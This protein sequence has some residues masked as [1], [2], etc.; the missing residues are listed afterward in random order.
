MGI[1]LPE[2]SSCGHQLVNTDIVFQVLSTTF[3]ALRFW[4]AIR[5]GRPLFADDVLICLAYA[6]VAALGGV[7]TWGVL[8]GMGK[9]LAEL[10]TAQLVIQVKALL[11]VQFT[12][13]STTV[14]AKLSVIWLLR[15]IYATPKFRRLCYGLMGL[16]LVYF[17]SFT[18]IY[19][20]NCIPISELWHH[21]PGGHCRNTTTGDY[22]T[23]GANLFLDALV[24]VLPLPVL[25]GLKMSV[26]DKITITAMFSLGTLTMTTLLWRLAVTIKVRSSPEWVLT[27]CQV[28]CIAQIELHVS[29]IAACIPTLGPLFNAYI[30]PIL[31]KL[32]IITSSLNRSNTPSKDTNTKLHTLQTIGSSR[33][34]RRPG[35]CSELHDSQDK[36]LEEHGSIILRDKAQGTVTAAC[37]SGSVDDEPLTRP[38]S[39]AI[40]VRTNIEAT[41]H[42]EHDN[43]H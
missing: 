42:S 10:T 23:I 28:G 41:Y 27:L 6:S 19:L 20:T 43:V 7:V 25:W 16:N 34:E 26:K 35:M 36:I 39:R 2:A 37:G 33:L 24:L 15:R 8:N 29:I 9:R 13:L 40:H 21:Q 17:V 32:S 18:I 5:S 12:Y 14:F 4:A 11:A 38:P 31:A 1:P 3:L 30:K 22:A